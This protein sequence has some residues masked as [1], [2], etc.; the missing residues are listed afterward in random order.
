MASVAL[1]D[2]GF[3]NILSLESALLEVG[4]EVARLEHGATLHAYDSVVVP[5]AGAFFPA[6]RALEAH[7]MFSGIWNF[8]EEL[9]RPILGI[10]LGFHALSSGSEESPGQPG[11]NLLPG[12]ARQLPSNVPSPFIGWTPVDILQED[13]LLEGIGPTAPFHITQTHYLTPVDPR[14]LLARHRIGNVE[15]ATVMR[16]KAVWGVQFDPVKSG[17]A[18]LQVLANFARI[19]AHTSAPVEAEPGT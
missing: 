1:L 17:E 14:T 5:G 7:G 4:L 8:Y 19:V 3:G 18:G 15:A 6:M 2:Y 12:T 11:L 13:P 16:R 10:N 9:R